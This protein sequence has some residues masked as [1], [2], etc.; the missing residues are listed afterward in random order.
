MKQILNIINR[1]L[2]TFF[3]SLMGYILI[4]MFLGFA[5]F[6]T[7]IYGQDIFFIGQASLDN[8]FTIS[9]WS[10]FFLIPALTMRSIAGELK[11]GTLEL[12]LTKPITHWEIILGKFGSCFLLI[13]ICLLPTLIYYFTLMTIGSVDHSAVIFAYIGLLLMSSVYISIGLLTSSMSSNPIIAYLFSLFIGL[14]LHI[15][16]GF[17]S[18][19][20]INPIGTILHHI[21][22]YTHFESMARGVFD[23]ADFVYF[24]S[25]SIFALYVTRLVI[26]AKQH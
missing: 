7:W 21:S 10:L 16:F 11:A 25:I 14:F 12:L 18:Q 26:A 23:L 9:Y 5:G 13:C 8:F 4:L 22:L 15:I 20:L 3:D 1:E 6:F 2:N 19:G 24:I 17:I